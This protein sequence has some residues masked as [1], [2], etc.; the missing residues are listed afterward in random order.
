[1]TTK[2]PVSVMATCVVSG[3]GNVLTHF[4]ADREKVNAEVYCE[5]LEDKIIPWMKKKRCW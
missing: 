5:V 4:L 2:K 1:M 3:E